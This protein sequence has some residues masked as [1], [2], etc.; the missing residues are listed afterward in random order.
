[1]SKPIVILEIAGTSLGQTFTPETAI[2]L[3]EALYDAAEKA[4]KEDR[5]IYLS[6]V[7]TKE[8]E[9]AAAELPEQ[10]PEPE[11][12]VERFSP[13]VKDALEYDGDHSLVGDAPKAIIDLGNAL[14]DIEFDNESGRRVLEIIRLLQHVVGGP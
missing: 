8:D 3:S 6:P 13:A 9:T 4:T 11:G 2:A 12:V 14:Y 7:P 5:T 1:M 10:P